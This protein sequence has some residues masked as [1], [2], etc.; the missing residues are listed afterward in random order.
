MAEESQINGGTVR[1]SLN[2]SEMSQDLFQSVERVMVEDE[3]NLP[4]MFII[5]FNT[6][7][8]EDESFQGLDLETFKLGDEIKIFMGMDKTEEMMVGEITALEP[9][10]GVKTSMEIRGF[11]RLHKLRFGR[12]RRS[13]LE[14]KDSDIASS[15]VSDVGLSPDVEDTGT[16]HAYL[17]QNN[18]TNYEF[19]YSRAKRIDYEMTVQDKTFLFKPS[20]EDKAHEITL[21][22]GIDLES[23]TTRLRVITEGSEV[24]VRGWDINNKEEISSTTG[25]GSERSKMGGGESGFELSEAVFP[26]PIAIVDYAVVDTTDAENIGKAK[27][28]SMIKQFM[29]GNGKIPGNPLVRAGKTI[30]IKGIGEKFSGVYYVTS[31]RHSFTMGGSYITSFK[32]KRTGI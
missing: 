13:F 28:N 24:E 22:N 27:Y 3:I 7:N 26:S 21:E 6:I 9:T 5:T 10:F 29:T 20:Q 2:G 19:L 14:M 11:D 18:Q 16:T 1:I 8:F 30:E 31:S 32:V 12:F 25:A 4:S 15:V 23:F 17:F